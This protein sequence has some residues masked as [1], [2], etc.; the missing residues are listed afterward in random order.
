MPT[1]KPSAYLDAAIQSVLAQSLQD[2]EIIV[3]DDASPKEFDSVLEDLRK[4]YPIQLV[5][6]DTNG[7]V[8]AA[9][10]S[11]IRSA[12]GTYVAF[13]EHDD[14]WLPEKLAKQ[15]AALEVNR[16]WGG[17]YVGCVL[18]D[19]NGEES[20]RPEMT[21]LSGEAV[22]PRLLQSNFIWSISSMM[23]R[24]QCLQEFGGFDESFRLAGDYDLWLRLSMSSKWQLGCVPERLLMYRL[25]AQ[26]ASMVGNYDICR[27]VLA[28]LDMCRK[29]LPESWAGVASERYAELSF[30]M[31]Q[32]QTQQGNFFEGARLICRGARARRQLPLQYLGWLLMGTLHRCAHCVKRM[33]L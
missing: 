25:H 19:S 23:L 28:A 7:G 12:S 33:L 27:D 26:N 30:G 32:L 14:I 22:F 1:Y 5:K 21:Y 24:R 3:V 6:R 17:C 10:N 8:A 15:V 29:A 4:R 2:F 9:H 16:T 18:I 11:G 20:S 31:A 13:L